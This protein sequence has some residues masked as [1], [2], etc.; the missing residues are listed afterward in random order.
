MNVTVYTQP[1]CQPCKATVRMLT[2][3][4]VPFEVLDVR[5]DKAAGE[6]ARSLG[7]LETPVV[8]ASWGGAFSDHTQTWAGFHPELIEA[9]SRKEAA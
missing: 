4:G 8:V 5:A 1:G 2:R 3:L 9:L 6:Y 7:F